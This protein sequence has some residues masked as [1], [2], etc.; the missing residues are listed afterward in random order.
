MLSRYPS[1]EDGDLPSSPPE[2]RPLDELLANFTHFQVHTLPHLLALIVTPPHG[3]PPPQSSL[4]VID[5]ASNL[6]TSTFPRTS[7]VGTRGNGVP[8]A[9]KGNLQW[10]ANRKWPVMGD[11]VSKL[12][13]LATLKNLAVVLT[14][15]TTT[16]VRGMRKP[17]LRPAMSGTAWEAGI[18]TR[19][20]L[21]RDWPPADLQSVGSQTQDRTVVRYAQVLK[22]GGKVASGGNPTELVVPFAIDAGGLKEVRTTSPSEGK[23]EIRHAEKKTTKRKLD[24]IADSEDEGEE[25]G[26]DDDFG[27]G[28]EDLLQE[29]F[30]A[31]H[32]ADQ[33]SG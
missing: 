9:K 29:V 8:E 26:S 23:S 33:T 30:E 32:D 12:G 6:F 28:D 22:A 2:I 20:V 24:E 3:F 11:F 18:N 14:G 25:I 17:V 31:A 1:P 15:Q 13:K 27:L 7:E 16:K 5:S 4:L 19:I 21:F 10:A